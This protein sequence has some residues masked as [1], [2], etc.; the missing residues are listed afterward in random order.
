MLSFKSCGVF[1]LNAM[2]VSACLIA[3]SY[4]AT[5]TTFSNVAT[6]QNATKGV[7]TDDFEGMVAPGGNATYP[8]GFYLNGVQFIGLSGSTVGVLD[9]SA[10]AWANF[11]TTDAGFTA[12][13]VPS[14]HIV[15]PGGINA[16]GLD[17]FSSP[18]A[19]NVTATVLGTQYTIPTFAKP[20]RAFFGVTSTA[21]IAS[22][23]LTLPGG[24]Y[25][26]FDNVRFGTVAQVP[27]TSTF[28]LIGLGLIVFTLFH[29]VKRGMP[30]PDHN[31]RIPR[32]PIQ[33]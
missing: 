30:R 17:L 33:S 13:T 6:W 21:L 19:M 22:V 14:V 32:L 20:T 4:P 25:S 10:L 24:T 7:Q 28:L 27:E 16:F 3:P 12:G 26:F 11:G 18:A 15:F 2:V 9:T 5:I 29:K 31:T 1:L 8:G 23:D